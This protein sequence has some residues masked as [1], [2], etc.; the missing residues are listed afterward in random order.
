MPIAVKQ[1]LSNIYLPL[2][3]Y[4]SW[5]FPLLFWSLNSYT[6]H[7]SHVSPSPQMLYMY[8]SCS[9]YLSSFCITLLSFCACFVFPS[10]LGLQYRAW[11]QQHPYFYTFLLW[12]LAWYLRKSLCLV[13]FLQWTILNLTTMGTKQ[14]KMW[15]WWSFYIRRPI[16]LLLPIFHLLSSRTQ[17]S[18][19][20]FLLSSKLVLALNLSESTSDLPSQRYFSLIIFY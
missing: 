18:I 7:S 13:R 11:P 16:C 2:S 12:H 8:F 10:F 3:F 20:Y 6:I 19:C 14:W 4:L 15:C 1:I 5:A 9:I 17:N